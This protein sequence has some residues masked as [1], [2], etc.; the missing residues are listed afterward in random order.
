MDAYIGDN[1]GHPDVAGTIF[2][3]RVWY[4][5]QEFV[6]G[7]PE[8][9]PGR[10]RPSAYVHNMSST[11]IANILQPYGDGK[12]H[13][14]HEVLPRLLFLAANVPASCVFLM[15]VSPFVRRYLSLLPVEITGR[16][17][18]W[19]GFGHVYWSERVYVASEGPFCSWKNPHRGGISTW[20]HTRLLGEVRARF[21]PARSEPYD[22][23]VIKRS[24]ARR[25][26][27]HD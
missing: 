13:F 26:V 8:G 21:R 1:R 10:W 7:V 5:M 4:Q 18:A 6:R 3:D 2:T 19:G 14:P 20:Y 17:L 9:E 11:C 23:L 22:V 24:H 12:G 27:E 25:Y 15:Q 16:V